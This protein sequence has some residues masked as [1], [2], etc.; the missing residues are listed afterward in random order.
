VSQ[1]ITDGEI[2]VPEGLSDFA[3]MGQQWKGLSTEDKKEYVEAAEADKKRF[4]K[5]KEELSL[6]QK[7]ITANAKSK[8]KMLHG[9]KVKKVSPYNVFVRMVQ[10]A[11]ADDDDPT[12]VTDVHSRLSIEIC[13][14]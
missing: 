3:F 1:K 6:E 10:K 7:E 11:I 4:E 2:A 14:S 13:C 8:S 12:V 5:E 9:K